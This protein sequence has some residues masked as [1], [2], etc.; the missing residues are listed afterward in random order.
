MLSFLFFSLA[1]H[2]THVHQFCEQPAIIDFEPMDMNLMRKYISLCK[3]KVPVVPRE[4]ADFIVKCYVQ[5]R[6]EARNCTD[7]TSSF[8][9]A[10]NLLAILRLATALTK[11]RL[12][13]VVDEGD[14]KEA[15][16]LLDMSKISLKHM[17][18]IPIR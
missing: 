15:I 12:A 1:K 6:I 17:D 5:I 11:L 9:S 4:L 3:K 16:R 7:N 13:D 18:N 2:I 10:R 8:T 14:V